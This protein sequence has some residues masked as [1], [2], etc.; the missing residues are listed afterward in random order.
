MRKLSGLLIVVVLLLVLGV[1]GTVV[2]ANS[3][4]EGEDRGVFSFGRMLPFMQ[5]H[6]AD[7]SEEELEAM[8]EA[9]HGSGSRAGWEKNATEAN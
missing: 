1:A 9:C 2:F 3:G 8:Y 7:L 6:H 5:E 4:G